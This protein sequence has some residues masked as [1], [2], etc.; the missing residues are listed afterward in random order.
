VIFQAES[1]AV[2]PGAPLFNLSCAYTS[3]HTPTATDLTLP[4]LG[5]TF[6]DIAVAA[7]P[8]ATTDNTGIQVEWFLD[9]DASGGPTGAETPALLSAWMSPAEGGGYL[10]EMNWSNVYTHSHTGLSPGTHYCYRFRYRNGDGDPAGPGDLTAFS[11]WACE[12]TTAN[13]SLGTTTC[14]D[15]DGDGFVTITDSL[16]MAMIDA[17]LAVAPAY[18]TDSFNACNVQGVVPPTSTARINILDAL[19]NARHVIGLNLLRCCT[20]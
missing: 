15:C 19:Y 5:D 16:R 12:M 9:A 4:S 14:G 1:A 7:P 20:P 3:V 11:P 2:T 17:G 6:I 8:R 18:G 10:D 13:C